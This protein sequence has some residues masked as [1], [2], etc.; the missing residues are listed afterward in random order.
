VLS[1]GESVEIE[2]LPSSS[3]LSIEADGRDREEAGPCD[4]LRI[5]A[6][7]RSAR[8]V[9]VVHVGFAARARA[10][11]PIVDAGELNA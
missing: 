4:R 2:V 10:K 7:S 6:S 9:R 1:A 5:G 8:R 11:L 3:R